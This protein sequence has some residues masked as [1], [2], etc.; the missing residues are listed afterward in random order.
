VPV[1]DPDNWSFWWPYFIAVLL[2]ECGYAVWLHRRGAWSHTVT[3]VNAGLAVLFTAPLV[4]LLVSHRFFNAEFIDRLDWGATNPLDWL[5]PAAVAVAVLTAIWD[6]VDVA[7]RAER[8]RR[9]LPT[10]VPGT[11]GYTIQTG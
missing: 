1:L 2:L 7:I 8:A 3:A 4:W 10:Q 6:V 11:G 9:G 5:T